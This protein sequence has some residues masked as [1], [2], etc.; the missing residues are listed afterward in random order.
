[1][2]LFFF[3]KDNQIGEGS[4]DALISTHSIASFKVHKLVKDGA[5]DLSKLQTLIPQDLIPTIKLYLIS[6]TLRILSFSN[7]SFEDF[8]FK[9]M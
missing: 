6:P 5:W 3:W 2:V 1:M 8:I 4:I 9:Y 7:V